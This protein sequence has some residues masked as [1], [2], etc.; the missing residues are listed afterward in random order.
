MGEKASKT[1]KAIAEMRLFNIAAPF[2]FSILFSDRSSGRVQ[3]RMEQAYHKCFRDGK[4]TRA[5]HSPGLP[6]AAHDHSPGL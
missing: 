6:A 5:D 4:L 3:Q 2:P 1:D